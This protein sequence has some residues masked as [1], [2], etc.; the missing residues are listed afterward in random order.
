[1]ITT[2]KHEGILIKCMTLIFI[3]I[4]G[5]PDLLTVIIQLIQSFVK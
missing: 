3:L 5:E 4:H 2:E 1:M